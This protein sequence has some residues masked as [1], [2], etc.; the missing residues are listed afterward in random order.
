MSPGWG[1]DHGDFP[2]SLA[3]HFILR[4][5]DGRPNNGEAVE[6]ASGTAQASASE[7]ARGQHLS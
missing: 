3:H 6:W 4:V 1:L 2:F 5:Y 7:I